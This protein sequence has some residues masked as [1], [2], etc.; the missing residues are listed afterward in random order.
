MA[1]AKLWRLE[2]DEKVEKPEG[3][4]V[5]WV[6][7]SPRKC[8]KS[9]PHILQMPGQLSPKSQG[10]E[11]QGKTKGLSDEVETRGPSTVWDSRV[12]SQENGF[13]GRTGKTQIKPAIWLVFLPAC[14]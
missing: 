7:F 5:E 9:A 4:T 12:L 6:L 10:H 13:S 11:Q 2:E 8:L 3:R 1:K 14:C